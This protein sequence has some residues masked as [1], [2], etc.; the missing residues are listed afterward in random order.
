MLKPENILVDHRK[1]NTIVQEE[2]VCNKIDW[3]SVNQ[4]ISEEKFQLYM[5]KVL[6]YLKVKDEIFVF[7]G[8]AG[9]DEN[10]RLPIQ[11]INEYAWHNLF[12]HQLF[13]R[14]TEEEL[15]KS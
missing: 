8:F 15:K 3:G 10:Y 14:P 9:A 11:V 13:I 4:P 5:H 7:K 2:S 1:T 12:A 6:D